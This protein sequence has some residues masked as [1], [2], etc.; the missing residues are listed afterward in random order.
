MRTL[1]AVVAVACALLAADGAAAQTHAAADKVVFGLTGD[2]NGGFNTT[3]NC[4]GGL[5]GA[6]MTLPVLHGAFVQDARGRWLKDLV[7]AARADAR[8]I[9]YTIRPDAFWYWGGRKIPVT[10]RDFVYTLRHVD[11][12]RIDAVRTGYA[13]LDPT[14]ITHHGLRRFTLF[15]RRTGCS[16]DYPCGPLADWPSLFP[17]LFPSFALAG[18]D[19]SKIWTSCICGS[20]G[21]PV[22]DGPFYLARYVPGQLAVLRANPYYH[23]R[24]RL[25]ELDF[26]IIGGDPGALTEAIQNGQVDAIFPSFAPDFL[27]LRATPGLTYQIGPSYALERM[28]FREGGARGGPGVTKSSSNVLLR[29]PWMRQAIALALDRQAMIDAVYG[30]DSGLK[31]ANNLLFYPGEAGYRADFS[32]WS[33]DPSKAIALLRRHCT[34]GPATPDPQTA[35]VWQCSGLPAVVQYTWPSQAPARTLIEQVARADLKAVGIHVVD[36]PSPNAFDAITI[37]SFDIAQYANFTSGDPG[38]WYDSYRCF[39]AAN[40]TGYCSRTVDRLLRAA[41]AQLDPSKRSALFRRADAIM[42]A[43]LPTIPLFQKPGTLIRKS[44]LLGVGPSPSSF[45]PFWNVQGWHWRP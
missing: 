34:G 2:I 16:T 26:K 3:L 32:R 39:G 12:P 1:A 7:S 29:A 28:D 37:G 10:Y 27:M 22:A 40:Y 33:T 35:K 13:N 30:P 24:A 23:D 14:R 15:W 18:E 19:F 25:A 4:C 8:G 44:S 42:A 41:N 43:Q 6:Y 20:D 9:S 45:G 11:D 38:D 17:L 36:R 5:P 21:M 31:P